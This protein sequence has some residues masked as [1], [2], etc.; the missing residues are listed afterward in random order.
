M[1]SVA[2][3]QYAAPSDHTQIRDLTYPFVT[4]IVKPL[5]KF[6]GENISKK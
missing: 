5:P 6:I 4:Y 3:L 2:K 1:K